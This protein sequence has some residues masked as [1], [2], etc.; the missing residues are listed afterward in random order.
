MTMGPRALPLPPLPSLSLTLSY[1]YRIYPTP[2]VFKLRY[3]KATWWYTV[4]ERPCGDS[5]DFIN[6]IVLQISNIIECFV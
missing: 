4:H 2:T 3:E 5:M 6:V 1:V